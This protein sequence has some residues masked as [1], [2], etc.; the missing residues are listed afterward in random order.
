MMA[1]NEQPKSFSFDKNH[2]AEAQKIIGR[3]PAGRQASAVIPL[4]DLAQRQYGGWLPT[5]AMNHVADILEMPAIRVYEVASFYTMY[6]LEPVGENYPL[7]TCM[8]CL[9]TGDGR[10]VSLP[11]RRWHPHLFESNVQ[12]YALLTDRNRDGRLH[13]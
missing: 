7:P 13:G 2:D 11:L 4:L 10:R 1:D 8:D 3:Y 5:A 12:I 6:N 9:R